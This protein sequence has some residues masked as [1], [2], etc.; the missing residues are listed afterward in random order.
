MIEQTPVLCHRRRQPDKVNTRSLV[1]TGELG[2]VDM[3]VATA[4]TFTQARRAGGS[5]VAWPRVLLQLNLVAPS[6]LVE[7]QK[8]VNAEDAKNSPDDHRHLAPTLVAVQAGRGQLVSAAAG[9]QLAATGRQHVLDPVRLR[10]V[11]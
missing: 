7:G 1:D 9:L 2:M 11:R 6:D 5:A 10:P 8:V 4:P 3:M